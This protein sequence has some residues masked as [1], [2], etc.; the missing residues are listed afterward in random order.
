MGED[1]ELRRAYA[2]SYAEKLVQE[3][4][5]SIK[6]IASDLAQRGRGDLRTLRVLEKSLLIKTRGLRAWTLA[7]EPDYEYGQQAATIIEDLDLSQSGTSPS[8]FVAPMMLT[9]LLLVMDT[10]PSKVSLGVQV[11][12]A[13]QVVTLYGR[14]PGDPDTL[15]YTA[16]GAPT[17]VQLTPPGLEGADLLLYRK[18]RM[19]G[20]SYQDAL[21]A[22]KDF[23]QTNVQEDRKTIKSKVVR[24][25]GAGQNSPKM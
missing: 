24:K 10:V 18:L 3:T 7:L 4:S 20:E 6:E 21:A 14:E 15:T 19:N 1:L 23:L 16:A 12:V 5:Q 25:S 8:I 2:V 11:K 17:A 9:S 22:T 13:G